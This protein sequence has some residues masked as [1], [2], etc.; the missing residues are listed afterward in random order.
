M[1]TQNVVKFSPDSKEQGLTLADSVTVKFPKDWLP[2]KKEGQDVETGPVIT[3]SVVDDSPDGGSVAWSIV[4][5]TA[6]IT[7]A[8]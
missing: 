5:G 8:T 2:E 3:V 4:L 6:C 7:F 1:S